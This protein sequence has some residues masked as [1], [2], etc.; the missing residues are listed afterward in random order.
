MGVTEYRRNGDGET[1]S[2]GGCVTRHY[3]LSTMQQERQAL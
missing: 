2:D 1:G 3:A